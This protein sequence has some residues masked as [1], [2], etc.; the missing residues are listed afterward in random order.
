MGL[1]P[2]GAMGIP[3]KKI[4]NPGSGFANRAFPFLFSGFLAFLTIMAL[5][6][7]ALTQAPM[8]VIVPVFMSVV[9]YLTWKTNMQNLADEV[10]DAGD[11]L[12]VR[13]NGQEETVPFSNIINV[14]FTVN[15]SGS[16]I[17]LTLDQ[18]G[19]FG[20]E[21]VFAPPSQFYWTSFPKNAI[22]EDLVSRAEKA[23][24]RKSA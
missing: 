9:G 20:A 16:R 22:A 18:P 15:R 24:L 7:G 12:L 4:S 11:F 13:K 6:Q 8:L 10:F 19:K 3:M 1:T 21:I 14:N 2:P 5:M 17:T 23:R